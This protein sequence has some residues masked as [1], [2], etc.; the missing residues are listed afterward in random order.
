MR[1]LVRDEIEKMLTAGVFEPAKSEWTTPVV[2]VPKKDVSLRFCVDYR[3]LKAKMLTDT[4]PLPRMDDCIDSLGDF[5][6]LTTL[7]ARAG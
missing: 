2:I 5:Q 4:Y 1:R 7:N 3:K 6:I